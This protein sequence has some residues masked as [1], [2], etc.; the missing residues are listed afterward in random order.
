MAKADLTA[1]LLREKLHYNPEIGRFF[2]AFETWRHKLGARAGSLRKDGY[3]V[4]ALGQHAYLAHRLAW[5]YMT[6]GWP[7]YGVDHADNDRSNNAWRNLRSATNSQNQHNSKL[8]RSSKS[9][10]R[11][12]TF[13]PIKNS[14]RGR[15]TLNKIEHRKRFRTAEEA[16]A[17]ADSMR[18]VLHAEFAY[19]AGRDARSTK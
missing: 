13:D 16:K 19:D 12:V 14:W 3:T 2:W 8:H 1:A 17:W 6:G 5:L 18:S 9:G 10:I 11:G 15:V 7:P 4:I